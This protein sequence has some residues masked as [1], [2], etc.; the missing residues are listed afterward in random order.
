MLVTIFMIVALLLF[1]AAAFANSAI[2][3]RVQLLPLGLAFVVA[4]WLVENYA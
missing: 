1:I 4:A 3:T 2:A